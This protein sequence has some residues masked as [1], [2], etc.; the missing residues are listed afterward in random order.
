MLIERNESLI[1]VERSPDT[2][3]IL[4][5]SQSTKK[6]TKF[7]P[8]VVTG[9]VLSPAG[10]LLLCLCIKLWLKRLLLFGADV[11]EVLL[12]YWQNVKCL[13]HTAFRCAAGSGLWTGFG[14]S[15]S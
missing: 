3:K 8:L 13:V 1:T 9:A 12:I 15:I 2:R 7:E 6:V 11:L 4:K 5:V 14:W 10:I